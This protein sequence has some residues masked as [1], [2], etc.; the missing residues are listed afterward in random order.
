MA[1]LIKF[2]VPG[3]MDLV[4][5]FSYLNCWFREQTTG[6]ERLVIGP[7][8]NHIELF[9]NLVEDMRGPFGLLYILVVPR[10]DHKPGRYQSSQPMDKAPVLSFLDEFRTYFEQDGR[11]HIW[12]FG[13]GDESQIIYDNHNVIFA[14]GPLDRF[15]QTLRHNQFISQPFEYPSPHVHQ[16]HAEFDDDEDLI[17]VEH[18]WKWFPL[19]EEIDE[20]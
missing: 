1:A 10:G 17:F 7:E 19:V 13:I 14:Y 6:P 12:I 15:E 11:H 16:Y 9:M 5:P 18:D 20:P 3:D 2:G 8:S 4:D